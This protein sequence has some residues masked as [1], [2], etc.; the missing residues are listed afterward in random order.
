MVAQR[1]GAISGI[2]DVVPVRVK[3]LSQRPPIEKVQAVGMVLATATGLAAV[4]AAA[5]TLLQG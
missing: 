5:I 1:I 2:D 3:G 4:G